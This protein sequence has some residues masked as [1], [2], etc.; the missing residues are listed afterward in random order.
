MDRGFDTSPDRV[1]LFPL[2]GGLCG[3]GL[4]DHLVDLAGSEDELAAG[5][6]G[7]GA[8]RT[9][10]TCLTCRGGE[11]HHDG[12]TSAFGARGPDRVGHALWAGHAVVVPV[13]GERGAV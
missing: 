12:R 11:A 3:A 9:H 2:L 6:G 7:G 4:L 13:D 8:L 5:A 1:P 10:W